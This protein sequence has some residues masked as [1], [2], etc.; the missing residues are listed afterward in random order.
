MTPK[1]YLNQA[2]HLDALINSRLREID[3]W[4]DMSTSISGSSS[5]G[6]PHNP[7]RSTEAHFVKC[8]AKVEE[9]Q[10]DVEMKVTWLIR[11]RDEISSR[12]DLLH[13]PSEQL[14]LRYHY[15]DNYTWEEIAAL[16]N[17]SLRT[18]YR[19]HGE[20]LQHFSVPN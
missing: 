8:L 3:Y 6:M 18:V 7:N 14:V 16:M 5:D 10:E 20:A 4:K 9:K 19:I 15:L 17:V 12:I 2:R 11:L 13:N 1:Q